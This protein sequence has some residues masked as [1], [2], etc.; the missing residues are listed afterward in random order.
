[1][2][3]HFL[4]E[5]IPNVL[6]SLIFWNR[7]CLLIWTAT[8]AYTF[9]N[10][11]NANCTCQFDFSKIQWVNFS[12][13]INNDYILNFEVEGTLN[14]KS[15]KHLMCSAK[16]LLV[17]N[18]LFCGDGLSVRRQ[19]FRLNGAFITNC[20][21]CLYVC[22]YLHIGWEQLWDWTVRGRCDA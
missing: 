16:L 15:R 11:K 4:I 19:L 14:P 5:K 3:L 7:S 1:M 12:Q 21:L 6:P 17:E 9:L 8:P 18:N 10:C 22:M 20:L 2:S 13:E